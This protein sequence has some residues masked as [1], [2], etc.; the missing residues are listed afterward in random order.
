[1]KKETLCKI[2]KAIGAGVLMVVGGAI[3][4]KLCDK[5]K[6]GDNPIVSHDIIKH[7]LK[8]GHEVYGE[9]GTYVKVF[10]AIYGEGLKPEELGCLGETIVNNQDYHDGMEFTHFVAIGPDK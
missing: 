1:M 3:G 2:G 7:V 9:T 6:I 4:W 8:D 5:V 10:G